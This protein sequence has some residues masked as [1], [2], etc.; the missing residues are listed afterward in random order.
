MKILE[1]SK[2][3]RGVEGD[4]A[5]RAEPNFDDLDEIAEG[6]AKFAQEQ[7][8]DFWRDKKW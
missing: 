4:S 1:K 3:W 8:L 5:K 2:R 7:K 6:F